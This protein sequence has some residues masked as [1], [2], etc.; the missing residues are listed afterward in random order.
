MKSEPQA[1]DLEQITRA[2]HAYLSAEPSRFALEDRLEEGALA[3]MD[4]MVDLYH[5]ADSLGVRIDEY[6]VYGHYLAEAGRCMLCGCSPQEIAEDELLK[7]C[8]GY[9]DK[10][11]DLGDHDFATE[12]GTRIRW[13]H[14]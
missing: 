11:G 5:L 6:S 1:R 8:P 2:T 14:Q 4:M 7:Y 10:T 9:L 13:T 3:L 12:D